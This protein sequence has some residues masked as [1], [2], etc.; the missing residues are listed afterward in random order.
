M[1]TGVTLLF[2]D[3]KPDSI[4]GILKSLVLETKKS[5]LVNRANILGK[6][7][8]SADN[9]TYLGINDIFIVSGEAKEGEILGRTS[10]FDYND[11]DKAKQLMNEFHKIE[12]GKFLC[13]LIYFC[14]NNMGE[15]FTITVLTILE[16]TTTPLKKQIEKIVNEIKFKNK[17][18]EISVDRIDK[19]DFI[20]IE[21]LEK[22]DLKFNVFET[23]YSDFDNLEILNEE[24][25]SS[26]DLNSI[27]NDVFMI[28]Q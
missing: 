19:I 6:K 5:E 24:I 8:A 1:Y 10:Y 22:T 23:L 17:I 13:S 18:V 4:L 25:L 28:K 7:I 21:S 15:K 2:Y 16:L 3:E 20:G 9:Y 27:L 26:S 12:T 14:S 11:I